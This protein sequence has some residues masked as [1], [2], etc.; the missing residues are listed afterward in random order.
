MLLV[1]RFSFNL[2][3]V[4]DSIA[5]RFNSIDSSRQLIFCFDDENY[6]QISDDYSLS[7]SIHSFSFYFIH[8]FASSK[9]TNLC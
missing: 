2:C 1:F 9:S 3:K 4:G 5:I 7:Y 6:L 8:L